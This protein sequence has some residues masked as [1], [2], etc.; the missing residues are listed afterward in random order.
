MGVIINALKER[1][2]V[3]NVYNRGFGP[4]REDP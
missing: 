2:V 4:E 1:K 3:L